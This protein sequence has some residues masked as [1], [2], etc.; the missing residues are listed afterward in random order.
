MDVFND[1]L[2][3]KVTLMWASRCGKTTILENRINYKVDREGGNILCIF[4]SDK[5]GKKWSKISLG[6]LIR[7]NPLL[8]EKFADQKSRSNENEIMF[9]PFI[10]GVLVIGG[11]NVPGSLSSWSMEEVLFDEI[12][13]YPPSAEK[14]GDPIELGMQRAENFPN[15]K[16]GFSSTPTIKGASRIEESWYES[17]QRLYFVPCPYCGAMQYLVFSPRSMFAQYGKGYLKYIHKG[18][19]VTYVAYECGECKKDILPK[20]KHAMVRHGEWRKMRPQVTDHAGF[21]ISRLYSPWVPWK[22]VAANFLRTEKRPE[23]YMVFVNKALGELYIE[24]VNFQFTEDEFLLRR[25]P[26]ENIPAGVIFMTVGIDVQDDRLEAIIWGWGKGE[27]AWFIERGVI[28]GSPEEDSTW[29]MLDQFILK[30]RYHENGYPAAYGK[31]GGILAV[32]VDTGDG[33]HSNVVNAYVAHRK[34]NRFFAIKGA[35]KPQKDFVITTRTK[36]KRNFLLLVDTFQGKKKIYYRLKVKQEKDLDGRSIPTPQ[37]MHFNMSCDKD[38]FEQLTSE[39]IKLKKINGHIHQVWTLPSGKRNEVLDCTDYAL[40]GL[41]AIV[42]GGSKNIDPFLEK[43]SHTLQFKFHQWKES[44]TEQT[45]EV[46]ESIGETD[47]TNEAKQPV[48]SLTQPPKK[49]RI[50]QIKIRI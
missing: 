26:Y 34:K 49:R 36:K 19:E 28:K 43:L 40:A 35:N 21:Q 20:H 41:H 13:E 48:Q 47:E 8:R 24:D 32:C 17:D 6:P 4:P 15:K 30:H 12:D 50:D 7:D 38:F 2:I 3:R 16:F 33:E 39:Q 18:N 29:T 44:N 45:N 25:E 42:P 46:S 27:E 22:E 37:L 14:E 5:K 23:R 10:G 31:I 11:A 1:P 9:K